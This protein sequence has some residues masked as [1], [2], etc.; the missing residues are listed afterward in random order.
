MR[1]RIGIGT[2]LLLAVGL[3]TLPLAGVVSALDS[4]GAAQEPAGQA[5]EEEPRSAGKV[6]PA[7][8]EEQLYQVSVR[9]RFGLDI[10]PDHVRALTGFPDSWMGIPLTETELQ[11]MERRRLLLEPV[12]LIEKLVRTRAP[13]TYAGVWL[14]QAAGGA[15]VVAMTD[16]S[17]LPLADV[18]ATLPAEAELRVET[19]RNSEAALLQQL[20]D[21]NADWDTIDA[22]GIDLLSTGLLTMENTVLVRLRS[23][24]QESDRERL[25]SRYG[26]PPTL[27]VIVQEGE[28][29][30]G[31]DRFSTTGA[32]YGGRALSMGCTNALSAKGRITGSQFGITAGHCGNSGPVYQGNFSNG[33]PL[34]RLV[35]GDNGFYTSDP[36]FCDCTGFGPLPDGKATNRVIIN[37]NFGDLHTYTMWADEPGDYEIGRPICVS[38]ISSNRVRC[39]YIRMRLA[40]YRDTLRDGTTSRMQNQ[41]E[42]WC[43]IIKGDSGAPAGDGPTWMGVLSGGTYTE[44]YC[45]N[46]NSATWISRVMY[47]D[48]YTN[49]VPNLRAEP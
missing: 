38:G 7:L 35:P 28:A 13:Q 37:N 29:G 40:T 14:D 2:I 24:A 11:E 22:L 34:G 18:R 39:E 10:R 26:H 3:A 42:M 6:A 49:N 9:E 33:D 16:E 20:N 30:F 17:D 21:V 46:P 23:G 27:R 48:N 44:T 25:L 5:V 8:T 36:T 43:N 19:V 32:L 12:A 4:D 47:V 41:I 1:R 15:V 31:T 45:G